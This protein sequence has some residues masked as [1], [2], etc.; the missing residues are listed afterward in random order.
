[1]RRGCERGMCEEGGGVRCEEGSVREG[2]V[3]EGRCERGSLREGCVTGGSVKRRVR[4]RGGV[5]GGG[6]EMGGCVVE[7]M[8]VS[9][10][11]SMVTM[12][13]TMVMMV[14]TMMVMMTRFSLVPFVWTQARAGH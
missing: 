6:G 2:C 12:V 14:V 13:V 3:R 10:R 5:R 9:A 7:G 8:S 11:R 1:M 4:G